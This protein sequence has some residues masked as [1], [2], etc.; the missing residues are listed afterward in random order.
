[1][2]TDMMMMSRQ[3]PLHPV[4]EPLYGDTKEKYEE[5][6]NRVNVLFIRETLLVETLLVYKESGLTKLA[7][8]PYFPLFS[9]YFLGKNANAFCA[10]PL[11]SRKRTRASKLCVVQ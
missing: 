10:A 4:R 3:K 1:M 7:A 2:M 8:F 5:R 9:P 11:I 6:E